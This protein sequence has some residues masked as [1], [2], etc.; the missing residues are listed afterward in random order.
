[1][2]FRKP[3]STLGGLTWWKNIQQ[4]MYFIM[5]E[6]KVGF[7]VWPYKYRIL[8]RENRMEIA[9][10]NDKNEINMDWQYLQHHAVPQLE[11]KI[12]LGSTDFLDTLGVVIGV[13][14]KFP[15]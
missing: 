3:I 12:D 7:P 2:A 9:N 4:D 15:L 8:M 5:Q 14:A 1:M 11:Q 6:H 13:I 10:S